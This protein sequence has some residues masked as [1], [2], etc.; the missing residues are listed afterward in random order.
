MPGNASF[1][2]DKQ[3]KLVRRLAA[4][5]ASLINEAAANSINW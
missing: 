4:K 1:F 2:K 5:A 3:Q